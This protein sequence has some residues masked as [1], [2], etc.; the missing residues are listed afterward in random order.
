MKLEQYLKNTS[1]DAFAQAIGVS[2]GLV[3]HWVTGRTRIPAE[4]VLTIEAATDGKV[5]RHELRPDLYPI[6]KK[7]A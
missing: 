4:R 7:A 2:Q 1:Q 5:T 6:E 3:S